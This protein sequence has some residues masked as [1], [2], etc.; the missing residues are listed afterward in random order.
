MKTDRILVLG[1]GGIGGP[2]AANLT[3]AGH[4]VTLVDQ[5][6]EHVEEIRRAGMHVTD[7]KGVRTVPVKALHVHEL[8]AEPADFDVVFLAVK[9]YDTE[10]VAQLARRHLGPD[11]CVVVCQNGITDQRVAAVVGSDSTLGCVVTFAGSLD[12]PGRVRR[13]DTYP[14]AFRVGE[15]SGGVSERVERLAD[16]LNAVADTRPIANLTGERWAKLCTN[17]MVNA[18]SG[19]SGYTASEVRSRDDTL[20]AMMQLGAETINVAQGPGH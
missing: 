13:A 16:L 6:P 14:I 9:S 3:E 7:L 5:W 1:G 12:K 19:L 20:A 10:W 4:D 11:G 18:L 8:Q 17:C 15:L 2:I